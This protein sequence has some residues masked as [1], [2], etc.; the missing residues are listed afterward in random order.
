M[1]EMK[2]AES[3]Q[4]GN[5]CDFSSKQPDMCVDEGG[6][7]GIAKDKDLPVVVPNVKKMDMLKHVLGTLL[8]GHN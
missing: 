6:V 1:S 2:K 8:T 3:E 5:V 7:L 4:F